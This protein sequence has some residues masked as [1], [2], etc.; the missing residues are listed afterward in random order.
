MPMPAHDPVEIQPRR[1]PQM[2]GIALQRVAAEIRAEQVLAEGD[3]LS[4]SGL[5]Q[6]VCLPCLLACFHDDGRQVG[7]ELICVD[8]VPTMLRLLESKREGSEFLPRAQPDEAAFA[9]V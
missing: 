3:G 6:T 5:I 8:L 9:H 2:I 4:G 1:A 7:A